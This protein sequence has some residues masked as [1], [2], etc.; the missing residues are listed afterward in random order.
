MEEDPNAED[1]DGHGGRSWAGLVASNA[2]LAVQPWPQRLP[3]QAD[4]GC[5]PSSLLWCCFTVPRHAPTCLP[6]CPPP[7]QARTWR[8]PPLAC[9]SGWPRRQRWWRCASWTAPAPVQYRTLLQAL[10]SAA[11]TQRQ[12]ALDSLHGGVRWLQDASHQRQALNRML[13]P[14]R[15][16][17]GGQPQEARCGHAEPGHPGGRSAC[18]S[19]PLTGSVDQTAHTARA[20]VLAYLRLL[21]LIS[22]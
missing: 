9:R 2:W 13:C 5:M 19:T 16:L 7:S 8:P 22:Q 3:L 14:M 1:C 17:G 20:C 6:H 12:P 11:H 10:V 15:R 21:A 18:G 4:A